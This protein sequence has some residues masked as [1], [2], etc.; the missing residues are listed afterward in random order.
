MRD[1]C[2]SR[3]SCFWA[4]QAFYKRSRRC[5]LHHLLLTFLSRSFTGVLITSSMPS[6]VANW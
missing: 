2:V 5:P 3:F 1:Y 6:V 4:M